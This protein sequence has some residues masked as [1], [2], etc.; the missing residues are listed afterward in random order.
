MKI[1]KA[2]ARKK[3]CVPRLFSH[4]VARIYP[5]IIAFLKPGGR[6]ICAASRLRL[7]YAVPPDSSAIPAALLPKAVNPLLSNA[8][9]HLYVPSIY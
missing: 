8:P 9:L 1:K 5:E 3:F 4:D 6:C 7:G 2:A